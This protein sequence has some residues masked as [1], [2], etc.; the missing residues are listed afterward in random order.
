[1]GKYSG[2]IIGLV[3]GAVV[4]FFVISSNNFA[5]KKPAESIAKSNKQTSIAQ[6]IKRKLSVEELA[7]EYL[8]LSCLTA[9]LADDVS[10]EADYERAEQEILRKTQASDDEKKFLTKRELI[11]LFKKAFNRG[12]DEASFTEKVKEYLKIAEIASKTANLK[13]M[14]EYAYSEL[15]YLY[16]SKKDINQGI[17]YID[18]AIGVNPSDAEYY[19]AKGSFLAEIDK[20]QAKKL[21]NKAIELNK[22]TY[23]ARLGLVRVYFDLEDP[24]NAK[25]ECLEILGSKEVPKRYLKDARLHL[26]YIYVFADK[27]YEDAEVLL[28]EILKNTPNDE[29]ANKLMQD[30]AYLKTHSKVYDKLIS[31]MN[32]YGKAN[33]DMIAGQEETT[34]QYTQLY[35][36]K[37][38]TSYNVSNK[39]YLAKEM[40]AKMI[41]ELNMLEMPDEQFLEAKNKL[42]Q[43]L[44]YRMESAEY[45]VKSFYVKAK[46]YQGEGQTAS[47]KENMGDSYYVEFLEMMKAI[48]KDKEVLRGNV[49]YY[50]NM[51]EYF[52][53]TK[54][55]E[56]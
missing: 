37:I 26:A 52:K 25:K 54:F 12:E 5:T 46:D 3:I 8:L 24:E 34:P 41:K 7:N 44:S 18:K 4:T 50:D 53:K 49:A 33:D 23:S 48:I 1:M 20:E 28:K 13:E 47:A 38:I 29:W 14:E 17:F 51:I 9:I 43:A 32:D 27:K 40:F 19:A 42:E 10:R 15:A 11:K 31:I 2:L 22:L 30:V 36:D 21:F 56:K 39:I 35:G 55:N 45:R 6:D 16:V